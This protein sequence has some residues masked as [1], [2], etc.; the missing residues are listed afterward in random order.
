MDPRRD[1]GGLLESVVGRRRRESAGARPTNVQSEQQQQQP[2]QQAQVGALGRLQRQT[3]RDVARPSAR[4]GARDA[5]ARRA[6][7][8]AHDEGYKGRERQTSRL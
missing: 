6:S 4:E 8:E 3:D 7:T 1:A 2:V 5:A